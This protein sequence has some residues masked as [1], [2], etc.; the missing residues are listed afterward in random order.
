MFK[1]KT[2]FV[3]GAGASAEM[4]FP[5][6]RRLTQLIADKLRLATSETLAD[7][8]IHRTL[9]EY[10]NQTP[11]G[12]FRGSL[13]DYVYAASLIT[14]AMPAAPSIDTFMDD[15]RG[16]PYIQVC[17]RLAIIKCIAESEYVALKNCE[18]GREFV[19]SRLSDTWYAKLF[20]RLHERVSVENL[21][22]LFNNVSVI[23]FNYD[24]SLEYYLSRAIETYYGVP[25]DQ[26]VEL[27]L[28]Q[29]PIVHP[30]S[31]VAPWYEEGKHEE[32]G[33]DVTDPQMLLELSR[34]IKTYTQTSLHAE[35]LKSIV[36]EAQVLVFLGF[37]YIPEN[38]ELIG[39]H[40]NTRYAQQIYGT[41]FETSEPKAK[42]IEVALGGFLSPAITPRDATATGQPRVVVYRGKCSQLFDEYD[43][44]WG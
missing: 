22:T 15:H 18:P 38:L 36:S 37:G 39:P 9:L 8:F 6:G 33:Q 44:L 12:E 7:Q 11:P 27:L 17:G 29:L 43:L 20:E 14:K 34:R 42:I 21:A 1:L 28:Q 19:L 16:N 5:T 3:L 2:V 32:L 10:V 13:I 35:R 26:A 4:S 40:P 23:N 25:K 30:Y 31:T 41:A 24:R